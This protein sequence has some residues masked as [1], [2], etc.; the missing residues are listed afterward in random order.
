MSKTRYIYTCAHTVAN[1]IAVVV[2]H[3]YIYIRC[4]VRNERLTQ[5]SINRQATFNTLTRRKHHQVLGDR[6]LFCYQSQQI[7]KIYVHQQLDRTREEKLLDHKHNYRLIEPLLGHPGPPRLTHL[8]ATRF[9]YWASN[10]TGLCQ[11]GSQQSLLGA[12][13]ETALI[14]HHTVFLIV[15]RKQRAWMAL[16]KL[17]WR[18]IWLQ[19]LF[20][21]IPP[22]HNLI[23]IFYSDLAKRRQWRNVK[24][25]SRIWKKVYMSMCLSQSH[26]LFLTWISDRNRKS[27]SWCETGL[28]CSCLA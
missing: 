18:N 20:C 17:P 3:S 5:V 4:R 19:A 11:L 28:P 10:Y 7:T 21:K 1:F 24:H 13:V 9:G 14:Q 15:W 26:Q 6:V 23:A 8:F 2:M 12:V 27:S 25:P 22:F 16:V